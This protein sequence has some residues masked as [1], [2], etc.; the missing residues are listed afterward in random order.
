MTFEQQIEQEIRR[1][2]D[3]LQQHEEI[4]AFQFTITAE[5]RVHDGEV[6]ITY[7]LDHPYESFTR[8]NGSRAQPVISEYVRRL[9]WN[10]V[11]EPLSISAVPPHKNN[12]DLDDNIIF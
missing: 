1:I 8:V 11:H 3:E 5:G 4:S 6:K 12:G 7:S 2:R 10:K 9:T